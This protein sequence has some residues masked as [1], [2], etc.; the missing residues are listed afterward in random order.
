MPHP[1][2]LPLGPFET[3]CYILEGHNREALVIDPSAEPEV[4][5]HRLQEER[6][7]LTAVLL[8]HGH[9]DHVSAL[10]EV[11]RVHPVPVLMHAADAAWTF[12]PINVIPPYYPTPPA[13]P[14]QLQ[15]VEDGERVM[16]AGRTFRVLTTPGHTPGGVCFHFEDTGD[17]FS[18]DTLFRGNVGRTDLPGS[19]P[20][21]MTASLRK[22]AA[23][24]HAT[25]VH[26]GHGHDTTIGDE[27]QYNYFM[28]RAAGTFTP[29]GAP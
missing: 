24:P 28:S 9:L 4:I 23:L 21:V 12:Q 5:L 13:R 14:A 29:Q 6:L 15:T 26:P 16:L 22:L 10:D 17:L 19:D 27:L 20:R 2:Q 1:I 11:V 8:T 18:G 3:N 25:R 7:H